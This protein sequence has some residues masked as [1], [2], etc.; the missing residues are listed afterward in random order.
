MM[1]SYTDITL[2]QVRIKFH[3]TQVLPIIISRS[4]HRHTIQPYNPTIL[5]IVI[6]IVIIIIFC[7]LLH[8]S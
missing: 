4:G 7:T 2:L 1:Q 3:F 8:D 5:F 6:G